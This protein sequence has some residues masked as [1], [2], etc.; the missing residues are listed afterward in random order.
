MVSIEPY[1]IHGPTADGAGGSPYNCDETGTWYSF[2][3]GYRTYRMV[4]SRGQI[5]LYCLSVQVSQKTHD[6]LNFYRPVLKSVY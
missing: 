4:S 3:R 5:N 1:G 6:R 2:S